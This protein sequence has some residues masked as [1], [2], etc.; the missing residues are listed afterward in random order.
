MYRAVRQRNRLGVLLQL[1]CRS[2]LPN[3]LAVTGGR[4]TTE[5]T[6]S[7]IGG[8]SI[9]PPPNASPFPSFPCGTASCR[10]PSGNL[11]PRHPRSFPRYRVPA[12]A[13]HESF[14]EQ[15]VT[16]SHNQSPNANPPRRVTQPLTA[17]TSADT[18]TQNQAQPPTAPG[19]CPIWGGNITVLTDRCQPFKWSFDQKSTRQKRGLLTAALPR[20]NAPGVADPPA[21]AFPSSL[22]SAFRTHVRATRRALRSTTPLMRTD[23]EPA[24]ETGAPGR[25]P[26]PPEPE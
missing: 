18:S 5:R 15:G 1:E 8:L 2:F 9:D 12:S 14:V 26:A 23:Y 16:R 24:P 21:G 22:R 11:G 25:G 17:S 7:T 3:A 10:P 6:R 19:C 4:Q 13:K 20:Y